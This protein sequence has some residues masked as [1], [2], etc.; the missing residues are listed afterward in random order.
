MSKFKRKKDPF[1]ERELKKYENPIP[2]REFILEY[3]AEIGRPATQRQIEEDLDLTSPDKQEALRRRLIAMARDGQL[4]KNRK[5]A[6]GPLESMELIAGRVIGHKDG[7]GFV[8]P[9]TGKDDLFLTPRQMRIVFHG[10]RVLT[11]VSN[12]DTRGRREAVIVEVLERNTQQIVGRFYS[13]SGIAF[14]ESANQ[15]ITHDILIPPDAQH[16]AQHGQ[17][18]VVAI[19]DQPTLHT[20]P[21]GK[22]IEVLGDHMAP[23]M[24]INVAIRNHDLPYV[25][26]EDVLLEASR[27]SPHVTEDSIIGREDLRHLPFVT[28]DG[29]DAK[30]F[31]DAVYCTPRE[32]GGWMLY[33]AIADVGYYV[34]PHTALDKEAYN[35][36][37]SVYFPGRVIPMLPETL[38]NNLCSLV[39]HVDRL[40]MVCEMT[41]HATGRIMKYRFCE[42]VFQSHARLTYNQVYAM[43]EKKDKR[44]REQFAAHVPHLASLYD[45][46]RTLQKARKARGA[47]D[48]DLPETKIV[49]GKDRKI[50]KIIPYERFDSHRVIEECMLCAN[51]C[52]AR[53]LEKHKQPGLY[54]VHQGPTE[55]KLKNL[56]KFLGEIGLSMPGHRDPVSGD[57]AHILRVIQD[58][59]DA[60][61]IQTIL[62]RSM[63]QAVYSAENRGHFGLAY[64]AYAHFTS[65]IRRYPDLLVHRSIKQI[66]QHKKPSTDEAALAKAGEHCSITERRADDAT[67]EVTDWLK[68]E[69]MM[70]K[71][72]QEFSGV[73]SGVMNFG[74]FVELAEIYV[75]GLVHIST[76]PDDYYLFDPIKHALLGERTGRRFRLGDQIKIRVARVDL[77]QREID[78]VLAEGVRGTRASNMRNR[79]P[80]KKM[81]KEKRD[82]EKKSKN[83]RDTK[84]KQ[85][86]DSHAKA[87]KKRRKRQKKS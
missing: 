28:I 83:Q 20:R 80:K 32:K 49:F 50:E 71:V 74:V 65:P 8:E 54:R 84:K 85:H 67:H 18:V 2:S 13:E 16:G 53:F 6:Y 24:E 23:G 61:M 51:I 31:D 66:L 9:D 10:D 58:R 36:G 68:C 3:L 44:M 29:E 12:V 11:R 1:A 43:M 45:L 57:Y 73:I 76:L 15:R 75:E 41:I 26:P 38:S 55:E 35:R 37:N 19:T 81:E 87:K 7:F 70:D 59:P 60:H 72:G 62:L 42:A 21:L 69:F 46:F 27:F 4:L 79:S 78:F 22:V 52:A 14:V 33:V 39:P 77:D 56:T 25:W 64:E 86:V 82:D 30:D 5:G 63:S 47:I 34:R 17:I 48:F 40:A